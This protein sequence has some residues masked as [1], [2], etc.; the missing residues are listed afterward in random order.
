MAVN[1]NTAVFLDDMQNGKTQS[2]CLQ[3]LIGTNIQAIEV[4]GEFF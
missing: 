4:R 2:D 1:V 3:A